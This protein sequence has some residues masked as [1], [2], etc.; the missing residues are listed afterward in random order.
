MYDWGDLKV[1]IAVARAGSTLAAARELGVNQTTVARRIVALEAAL[2]ARLFDRH[3]DGYRLSECGRQMIAQAERVEA[4]AETLARLVAQ[5]KRDL[6][7]VVRV[8]TPEIFANVVLAP[9]LV[10]FMEL[11]PDIK[12]EVLATDQ[13]LD[14]VRGEADIAV[15]A[16]AMPTDP[17]LVLRRLAD[18]H[19]TLCCSKSYAQKYGAPSSIDQLND[20]FVIG[21]DGHL[22]RL[23]PH[24]WLSQVAPHAKRRSTCTSVANMIA[25][26]KAGHGVGFLPNTVLSVETDLVEC[27][28]VPQSKYSFYIAMPET[29]KDQPRVRVFCDFLVAQAQ[30][31]KHMLEGRRAKTEAS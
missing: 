3:Q 25:A 19:W 11:Y 20:H 8:T 2:G 10:S 28:E 29:L 30:V 9:W 4:E 16:G 26:I 21:S 1:F 13:R 7:G 14:L 17:G 23:V 6:S 12:V 18:Y 27:F 15:R 24:I 31:S 22:S 5:R